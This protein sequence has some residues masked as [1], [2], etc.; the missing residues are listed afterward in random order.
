[1]NLFVI[2]IFVLHCRIPVLDYRLINFKIVTELRLKLF[3][4]QFK[5][6]DNSVGIV[7]DEA[8][9]L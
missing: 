9:Y 7:Q 2:L 8:L 3:I 5:I 4:S 1:M 6:S